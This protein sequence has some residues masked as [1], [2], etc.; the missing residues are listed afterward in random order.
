VNNVGFGG[1]ADGFI[2]GGTGSTANNL[3][4]C[5]VPDDFTKQLGDPT[6]L[7]LAA[8]LQFRSSFTC[9][10]EPPSSIKGRRVNDATL[11][12]P[13]L[14]ENRIVLRHKPAG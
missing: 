2:P 13:Q 9:P 4:G 11:V 10:A 6:E 3:P 5:V 8:A 1:Y 7:R 14:F 12:R